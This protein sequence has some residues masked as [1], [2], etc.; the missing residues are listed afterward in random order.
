MVEIT[1]ISFFI[2]KKNDQ[3]EQKRFK[4]GGRGFP[5]HHGEWLPG[6]WERSQVLGS[7]TSC[8]HW[9]KPI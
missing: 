1:V 9:Q 6:W 4:E 8:T 2:F 7:G 3:E 5:G